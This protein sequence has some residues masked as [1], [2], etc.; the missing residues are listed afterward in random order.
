[1]TLALQDVAR[2]AG[3]ERPLLIALDQENGTVR[4]V[5]R[6]TTLFPGAMA[7]GAAGST[8]LAREVAFAS[9]R[10]LRALGVNLNLA[11]VADVNN[12]PQNPV[13]GVRSFGEDTVAVARLIEVTV[14]GYR[15]AGM[16]TS[17]KHFPGHGDT[18]TDSHLDLPVVA[19]SLDRL[20]QVEL[21]PF[22]AGLQAGADSVM[23]AHLYLPALMGSVSGPSTTSAA[24]VD[25]LLRERWGY[26][27][28]VVSDCMEMRAVSE[29][30][31]T[32]QGVLRALQAG[33]DLVIVS[34][35]Y[36]RQ[37]GSLEAVRSALESGIL[38]PNR[39]SGALR[40]VQAL[41]SALA[42]EDLPR[43]EVPEWVGGPE[44][45]QLAA[46]AYGAAVTLV[47]DDGGLLPLRL[48]NE[49]QLLVVYPSRESLTSAEE[50]L[51]FP[52]GFAL[53]S[54]LHRHPGAVGCPVSPSPSGSEAEVVLGRAAE[55]PAVLVITLNASLIPEQARLVRALVG[56]G[57]PVVGIAARNPYD[58]T[59]FPELGAYL[60]T[61][62]YD[63]PALDAAAQ[64]VFGESPP[65]GHLPVTLP[66]L[67][68]RGHGLSA[69]DLPS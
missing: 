53:E 46:R 52:R 37:L 50:D 62:E 7:L 12:N 59:A 13:I 19:H 33:I 67:Y 20:E 49:D 35:T 18:A 26:S 69:E 54:V 44:H 40:R 8:E 60:C 45:Q 9:G 31:G 11:P 28:A 68:P 5:K 4:R 23:I 63:P 58:L 22:Q 64:V 34:H 48:D 3:H 38:G 14:R 25:G 2:R 65:R 21:A 66:G 47:R 1:L 41:K 57:R 39:I 27:G 56:L 16:L 17:L 36:E 42:W 43:G 51:Q 24:V 29:S 32:E 55:A 30:V 6:G 61:Y 15:D 10:E